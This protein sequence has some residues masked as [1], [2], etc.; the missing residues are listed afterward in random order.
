VIEESQLTEISPQTL[1]T[2]G[3]VHKHALVKVLARGELTRPVTVKAHRFSK[4]AEAAIT[5]AGGSVELLPLP[6]GDRRLR[7]RAMPL[8]TARPPVVSTTPESQG[9]SGPC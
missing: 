9:Y 4:A 3:L 7:Q 5:A 6:W 2:H 1:Y 8:Q